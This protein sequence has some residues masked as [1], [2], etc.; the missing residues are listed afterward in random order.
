MDKCFSITVS[1]KSGKYI[2]QD[3]KTKSIQN[4]L[5]I[6]YLE[7]PHHSIGSYHR[8]FP[9]NRSF[10]RKTN[11]IF[12]YDLAFLFVFNICISGK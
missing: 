9:L 11:Q 10:K 12:N 5:R 8:D 6:I 4:I 7:I 3:E 1:I 2:L